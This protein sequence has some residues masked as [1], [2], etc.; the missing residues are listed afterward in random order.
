M[1]TTPALLLAAAAVGFG[2]AILPDHW[3]PLAVTAR[4]ERYPLRRVARLGAAA[5]LAHVVFSLLLGAV[6][7]AVGLQFRAGV[8]AHEGLIVGGLLLITGAVLLVTELRGHRHTA[9]H[10]HTTAPGHG[11]ATDHGPGAAEHGHG[12][13]HGHGATRTALAHPPIRRLATLVVPFGAAASPDLTILPVFLAAAAVGPATSIG[14]LTVFSAVTLVTIVGLTVLGAI[15]G[16][17]FRGA[18][19]DQA[20]DL[21]TALMLLGIGALVSSGLS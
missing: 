16:H 10:R 14:A 1:M 11:P 18:R 12:H 13:G 3:V 19:I 17:R 6:I 4:T 5:G 20:A 21:V 9:G 7:I 2:H 15:V 8:E